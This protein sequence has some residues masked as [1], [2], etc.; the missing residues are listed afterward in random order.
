M[1]VI[2]LCKTYLLSQGYTIEKYLNCYK[3]IYRFKFRFFPR[4]LIN[5]L[6]HFNNRNGG[7]LLTATILSAYTIKCDNCKWTFGISNVACG[8]ADAEFEMEF[9][10]T[11]FNF[12]RDTYPNA[13]AAHLY[14]TTHLKISH[15]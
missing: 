5:I 14:S 4:R 11:Q 7:I 2:L 12:S 10:N 13:F 8:K 15:V 6:N 1:S 3:R 9:K